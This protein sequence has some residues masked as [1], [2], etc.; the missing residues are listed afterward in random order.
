MDKQQLQEAFDASGI[1][2]VKVGGFDVDGL[3]RGKYM[4][5]EKFWSAVDKGFGFCDVIFGWDSADALYDNA[6]VTGWHSGYP[7][8]RARID[9][10]TFRVLPSEPTTAC[11][12]VDFWTDDRHPHPACPRNLLKTVV[13]RCQAAGFQPRCGMELEYWLFKE[14]AESLRAKSYGDLTPL[15]PGMFGYSWVRIGQNHALI[16]DLYRQ[17]TAFGVRIEGFHT[18]TGP[19][20]YE[21]ALR[22]SDA[23]SA[24]DAAALFKTTMKILCAQHGISVTFMA[25]WNPDL[26]G[27]SGHIHQSLLDSTAEKNLFA[28][29]GAADGLST[30]ARQYIGGLVSLSP[31][32]TALFS[33]TINSYKRYVPGMWAP[34]TASWG[35]E[36]RTCSIRAIPG[37]SA[38]RVEFR[39]PAADL[40]PYIALAGCLAAGLHGVEKALEP[41][42]ASS[43]DATEA[44]A[45]PALPTTLERAVHQLENSDLVRQVLPEAFVEHYVITRKWELREYARSVTDW[46]LARY[47]EAI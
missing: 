39:Q 25:K 46:E 8:T 4:S 34:M 44:Q 10:D 40:N 23:V 45:A 13:A 27:S 9:L 18:E 16:D 32:L 41:P 19:G 20:V 29:P 2:R 36:N 26:P 15:S 11:F 42:P 30:T 5:L 24:A 14:D 12:L 3:L 17:L 22:Y 6:K 35:V 37:G 47:F 31:D 28:D 7:D 1:E 38:T 33:P 21:T 43:G